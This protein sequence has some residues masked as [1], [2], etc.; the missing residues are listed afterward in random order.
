MAFIDR[1]YQQNRGVRKHDFVCWTS[2]QKTVSQLVHTI[3]K[4]FVLRWHTIESERDSVVFGSN[5]PFFGKQTYEL[6]CTIEYITALNSLHY[7]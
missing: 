6:V 5:V 4:R 3:D 7:L 2:S 1:T